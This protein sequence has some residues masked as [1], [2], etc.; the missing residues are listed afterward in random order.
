M[1]SSSRYLHL[2]LYAYCSNIEADV[3]KGYPVT[4]LPLAKLKC[5]GTHARPFGICV[6]AKATEEERLLDFA[7]VWEEVIPDR[8]LP[9]PDLAC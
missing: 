8:P 1:G 5:E 3:F 4:V 9:L 6:M 7:R 2:L